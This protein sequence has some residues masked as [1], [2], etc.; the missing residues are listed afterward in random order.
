M[1]AALEAGVKKPH[2]LPGLYRA[3]RIQQRQIMLVGGVG[4]FGHLPQFLKILQRIQ[5][6]LLEIAANRLVKLQR[7]VVSLIRRRRRAAS[8]AG[9]AR[10]CRCPQSAHPGRAG[11]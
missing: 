10:C 3:R 8:G 1:D 7:P 2:R 9:C 4:H 5:V 11:P 6:P